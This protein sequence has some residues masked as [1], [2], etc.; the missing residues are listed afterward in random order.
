MPPVKRF[1]MKLDDQKPALLP[2][3]A[4]GRTTSFMSWAVLELHVAVLE[5][6]TEVLDENSLWGIARLLMDTRVLEDHV[7]VLDAKDAWG[8]NVVMALLRDVML[9]L[10]TVAV[11]KE[12]VLVAGVKRHKFEYVLPLCNMPQCRNPMPL[13][14]GHAMTIWVALSLRFTQRR[15]TTRDSPLTAS[16]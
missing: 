12:N 13:S 6:H 4:W 2:K 7:E 3:I 16:W 9:P 8:C 1:N 10:E 5:L 15:F 11:S 14:A